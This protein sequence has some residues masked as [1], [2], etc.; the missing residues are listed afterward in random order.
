MLNI[1]TR[2]VMVSIVVM[3]RLIWHMVVEAAWES[4]HCKNA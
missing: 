4:M 3:M 1:V 2:P